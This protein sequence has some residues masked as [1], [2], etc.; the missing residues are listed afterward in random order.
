MGREQPRKPEV[1]EMCWYAIN[2]PHLT[3]GEVGDKYGCSREWVRQ[4]LV[5]RELHEIWKEE[6]R[7]WRDGEVNRLYAEEQANKPRREAPGVCRVCL[8][9]IWRT[10]KSD[11]VP[12]YATC[13]AECAQFWQRYR[14]AID[15]K[16]YEKHRFVMARAV[17]RH[18]ESHATPSG[19]KVEWAKRVLSDNPP[20]KNRRYHVMGSDAEWARAK[21]K[22]IREAKARE[23][24]DSQDG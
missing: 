12:E 4:S 22:E 8:G 1:E 2:N 6:R 16:E 5:R 7:K 21:V 17:L 18:P 14:Y 9:P 11:K 15:E 10:R 19:A 23:M 24:E 13:G 3:A 20:P